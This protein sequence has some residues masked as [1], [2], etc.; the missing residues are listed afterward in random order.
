MVHTKKSLEEHSLMSSDPSATP[1]ASSSRGS[2]LIIVLVVVAIVMVARR[3]VVGMIGWSKQ[4]YGL[5]RS[6][7]IFCPDFQS[8]ILNDSRNPSRAS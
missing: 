7:L 3:L 8:P 4:K 5:N 1:V 2:T 6:M